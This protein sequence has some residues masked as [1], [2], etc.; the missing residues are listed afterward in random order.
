[1]ENNTTTKVAGDF[2]TKLFIKNYKDVNDQKVR[3]QFG[4]LSS[5][6]GIAVNMLLF[7]TKFIVGTLSESV[8][9]V[10]DAFNNLSDA[11]SSVISFLSFRMSNKPADQEHPFGHA[12]IE[13][14]S[15]SV[16]A[17]VILFIGF[18][19]LKTSVEKIITPAAVAFNIV[20]VSVLV[21]S[22]LLKF[23]LYFFNKRI[24]LYINSTLMQATAADSLSDVLSTSVVLLSVI[25]GYFTN[26]H[27]DGWMGILV[28]L[29]ILVSGIKILRE[30]VDSII[31]RAPSQELTE[32]IENFIKKYDGVLGI[33]DL[34][35]HDYGPQHCF[36]SAHVEVD[37]NEDILKSHD[38]IDNIEREMLIEHGIHL[39]IH[40]DPIVVDDPYVNKMKKL[41]EKIVKDIDSSLTIHD[42]RVVEGTTHN[43]LIFDVVVPYQ[44]KLSEETIHDKIVEKINE[45]DEKLYVVLTVDR[46]F[47]STP[48]QKPMK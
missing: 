5:I 47:V 12:R 40:L 34:V 30:T 38:L 24:G 15:S 21:L 48:N 45:I 44:C 32:M 11:G 43:N 36:A 28:S 22:I 1:M 23:W 16:V 39:V 37:A 42:F 14:I 4:N 9:V 27:L 46:C 20:T 18:E 35:V 8:S 7:I 3:R 17:V 25:V 19:L 41:T 2:L 31:G 10:G 26:A 33:H 29:F 13:Y 6:A